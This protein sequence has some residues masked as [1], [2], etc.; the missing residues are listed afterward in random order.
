MIKYRDIE[1][2]K[3][4]NAIYKDLQC[5]IDYRTVN[6]KSKIKNLIESLCDRN[7]TFDVVNETYYKF[8]KETFNR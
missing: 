1:N 5:E 4:I 3:H 2:T 7:L 6:D 8:L